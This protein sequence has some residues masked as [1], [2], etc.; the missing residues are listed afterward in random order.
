MA[1]D[2]AV[3]RFVVAPRRGRRPAPSITPEAVRSVPGVEVLQ[4]SARGRLIIETNSETF[5]LLKKQ[6][7]DQLIIEE[8]IFH[9]SLR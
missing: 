4:T 9:S 5:A 8:E 6:Y 2:R 1:N 7:G 3:K